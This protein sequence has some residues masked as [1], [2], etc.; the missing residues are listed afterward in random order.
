MANH[1][2]VTSRISTYSRSPV[3]SMPNSVGTA[4][5]RPSVPPVKECRMSIRFGI[6]VTRKK[7]TIASDQP[8]SRRP[9]IPVTSPTTT[10]AAVAAASASSTLVA[11]SSTPR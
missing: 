6:R 2:A 8:P 10:A 11:P 7:V 9:G 4:A 3:I 5:A 1:P